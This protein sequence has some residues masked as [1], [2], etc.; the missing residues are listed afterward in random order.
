MSDVGMRGGERRGDGKRQKKIWKKV[1]K[2][3][4]LTGI[5]GQHA[6]QEWRLNE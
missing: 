4:T 1:S 3:K 6:E 2:Q 5:K